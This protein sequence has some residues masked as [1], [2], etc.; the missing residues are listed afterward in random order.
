M[1]IIEKLK[2]LNNTSAYGSGE[3]VL[4]QYFL[5]NLNQIRLLNLK[6]VAMETNLSK[7]SIIRFCQ[8]GGFDGFTIFLDE[9]AWEREDLFDRINA[10]QQQS[11][12]YDD[13]LRVNYFKE[14][15]QLLDPVYPTIIEMLTNCQQFV[16]YGH[17]RYVSCF[18]RLVSKGYLL[19]KQATC[20][21][22]WD[23]DKQE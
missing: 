7:S 16:L 8:K 5:N 4:S 3:Y 17:E 1:Y 13:Q 14:A 9:L 23:I 22:C 15:K 21:M 2:G 18:Q 20:N 6:K 12:I 11:L 19:N 10:P